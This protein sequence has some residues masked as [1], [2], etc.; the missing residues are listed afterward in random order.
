MTSKNNELI[1]IL[2]L[3]SSTSDLSLTPGTTPNSI[4]VLP[5]P[6][7]GKTQNSVN[8]KFVIVYCA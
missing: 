4:S 8:F 5:N 6:S 2:P 1:K 7:D 3:A